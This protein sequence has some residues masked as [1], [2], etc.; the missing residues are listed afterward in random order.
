MRRGNSRMRPRRCSR[1]SGF[2]GYPAI[3]D[4]KP[5]P[6]DWLGSY[7]ATYVERDVRQVLNVTDL[8]AFQHFVRLCAGRSGQLLNLSALG[9]D[10]GVTHNTARAWLSVLE[11]SY[12]V[13]R[14]P[15]LHG[16]VR[17]RLVRTPKLHFY[18]TGLLCFLLGILDPGQLRH[19]PL[20]GAVFE[21]WVTTEIVKARIHRGLAPSLSFY[22][23]RKGDEI[24]AVLERG[25]AIVAIEAKSGQT[26]ASDFFRGIERFMSVDG[27]PAHT[28]PTVGVVVYGGDRTETSGTS[29]VL[30]WS[31]IAEFNWSG[32]ARRQR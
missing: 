24:D 13:F 26:V 20:R 23:D 19:H 2:G 9:A 6:A 27:L 15:A 30:P 29:R 12:I 8:Q 7:L 4:R 14:L 3:F 31:R 32:G 11:A 17:K 18:D 5:K 1:R 25:D 10:A 16:N 22:R 28:T 21:S